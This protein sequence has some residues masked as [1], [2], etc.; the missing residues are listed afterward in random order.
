MDRSEL[1]P[2]ADRVVRTAYDAEIGGDGHVSRENL[3][4]LAAALRLTEDELHQ[5]VKYAAGQQWVKPLY[6]FGGS[7]L[8]TSL[9]I[10]HRG[11]QHVDTLLGDH[12][13]PTKPAPQIVYNVH[14]PNARINVSSH[15][16]SV[17]IVDLSSHDQLF[18]RLEQAIREGVS[19][20]SAEAQL[21]ESVRDLRAAPDPGSRAARYGQLLQVGANFMTILSPFIPALGEFLTQGSQL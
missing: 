17:N 4:T 7:R 13:A 6:T 20:S 3:Q 1:L 12:S 15:D 2:L 9:D 10:T 21:L 19:D 16:A 8:P 11:M 14:G 5:A 18:E